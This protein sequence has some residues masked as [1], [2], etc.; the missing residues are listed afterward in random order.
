[1]LVVADLLD[2]PLLA[3][4]IGDLGLD[5][6]EALRHALLG[7]ELDLLVVGGG[8]GHAL[9]HLLEVDALLG[10]GLLIVEAPCGL[11]LGLV[12]VLDILWHVVALLEVAGGLGH[13]LAH[14]A[15]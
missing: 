1:M 14:L 3:G 2:A 5:P 13:A 8:L 9:A 6:L 7:L 11:D 12:D 4:D 15:S 10:L